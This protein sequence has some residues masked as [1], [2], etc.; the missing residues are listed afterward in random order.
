MII[1]VTKILDLLYQC[2]KHRRLNYVDQKDTLDNDCPLH[3]G[4]A[5]NV[6]LKNGVTKNLRVAPTAETLR[7][8]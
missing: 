6:I 4:L 2:Y 5:L 1:L 8:A 3:Q 7:Y